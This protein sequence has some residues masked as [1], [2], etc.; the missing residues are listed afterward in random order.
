M[1][2]VME[3]FSNRSPKEKSAILKEVGGNQWRICRIIRVLSVITNPSFVKKVIVLVVR[4]ICGL[5]VLLLKLTDVNIISRISGSFKQVSAKFATSIFQKK[6]SLPQNSTI[7]A[8]YP[9]DPHLCAM[10]CHVVL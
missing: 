4:F 9:R 1:L 10:L 8:F 7:I 3:L 5:R 2:P 6:I